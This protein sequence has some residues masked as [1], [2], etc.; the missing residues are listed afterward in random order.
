MA[1]QRNGF[2]LTIMVSDNNDL[3]GSDPRRLDYAKVR[4]RL[5]DINDNAP[6]FHNPHIQVTV[7]EDLAVGSTLATFR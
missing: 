5:R 6:K 7:P 4:I 3:T 2:N 1:S